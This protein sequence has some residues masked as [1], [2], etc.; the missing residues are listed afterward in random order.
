MSPGRK[1][2]PVYIGKGILGASRAHFKQKYGHGPFAKENSAKGKGR[3]GFAKGAREYDFG[4]DTSPE[5]NHQ[6]SINTGVRRAEQY[7]NQGAETSQGLVPYRRDNPNVNIQE[8]R[9]VKRQGGQL[10]SHGGKRGGGELSNYFH[11]FLGD[12][13]GYGDIATSIF[14]GNYPR[15]GIQ[16]LHKLGNWALEKYQNRSPVAAQTPSNNQQMEQYEPSQV[17]SAQGSQGMDQGQEGVAPARAGSGPGMGTIGAGGINAPNIYEATVPEGTPFQRTY[18]KSYRFLLPAC[19]P[20]IYRTA[21]N[22]FGAGV[23]NTPTATGGQSTFVKI[24]SSAFIPM[25]QMFMYMDQ[26]EYTEICA[27]MNALHIEGIESTVHL[28]GVRAPYTTGSSSIEVAN[29]NLQLPVCDWTPVAHAYPVVG[30]GPIA[31]DTYQ[32]TDADRNINDIYRKVCG[33]SN[34]H[35]GQAVRPNEDYGNFGNVS[36]RYSTRR[37]A[38]RAWIQQFEP[39]VTTGGTPAQGYPSGFHHSW[40]NL[41]QF[42]EKMVNGSNHLGMAFKKE[43]K[44]DKEFWR[45]TTNFH[46]YPGYNQSDNDS[47][48]YPSTRGAVDDSAINVLQGGPKEKVVNRKTYGWQTR[49]EDTTITTDAGEELT[50]VN[51][52]YDQEGVPP[53]RN[54]LVHGPLEMSA[55]GAHDKQYPFIIGLYNIRNITTD[56]L[57][58]VSTGSLNDIVDLNLEFILDM[59]MHCTGYFYCPMYWNPTVAPTPFV[60]QRRLIRTGLFAR[61]MVGGSDGITKN[62][63]PSINIQPQTQGNDQSTGP[64]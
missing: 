59:T 23:A 10:Q 45:R 51:T 35:F 37:Y 25:A 43:Y 13:P 38:H 21:N 7:N 24:E 11:N 57:N 39:T 53:Y 16:S 42:C 20:R 8:N 2:S 31:P 27:H 30:G 18:T 6:I 46:A 60:N 62:L 34:V 47:P 15:A 19:Q 64:Y 55:C 14:T 50:I 49:L 9:I 3:A 4:S 58:D 61:T 44:V 33:S 48:V 22:T 32:A 36:A 17:D 29:A 56:S 40:P 1:Q 12:S 26:Y 28:L 41:M 5:H 52:Q 54:A 63:Q